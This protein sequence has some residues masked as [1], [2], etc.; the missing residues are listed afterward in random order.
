MFR[1]PRCRWPGAAVNAAFVRG[2][3]ADE[4]IDYTTTPDFSSVAGDLDIVFETV[5]GYAGQ[6]VAAARA[7]LREA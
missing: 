1:P 4:P 6:A 2:L 7:A 3:G 5:G